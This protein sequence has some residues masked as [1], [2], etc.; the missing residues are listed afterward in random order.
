M[1]YFLNSYNIYLFIR[2]Y[3]VT[4]ASVD[5]IIIF[6]TIMYL[7]LPIFFYLEDIYLDEMYLEAVSLL[8]SHGLY[9]MFYAPQG[10]ALLMK[11]TPYNSFATFSWT[12]LLQ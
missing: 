1:D 4:N 3:A 11:L 10:F 9:C 8:L 12:L 7:T 6:V 5:G 2:F